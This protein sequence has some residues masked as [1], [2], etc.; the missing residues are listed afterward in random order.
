[1]AGTMADHI[2]KAMCN[3]IHDDLEDMQRH[4][5][6]IRQL[7]PKFF[8]QNLIDQTTCDE[9]FSEEVVVQ[10][11]DELSHRGKDEHTHERQ[12]TTAATNLDATF[13]RIS[14]NI[15][16]MK[17]YVERLRQLISAL[18]PTNLK[19]KVQTPCS[20]I[21]PKE[22]AALTCEGLSHQVKDEHTHERQDPGMSAPHFS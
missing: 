18:I 3:R 20:E 2:F 19:P 9:S 5:E 7:L 16:D 14:D 11:C 21:F 6:I 13:D 12:G 1:M 10:A 8:P 22:F 17:G 15:E 4:I